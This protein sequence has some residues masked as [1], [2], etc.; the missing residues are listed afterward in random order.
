MKTKSLFI[1][2][3]TLVWFVTSCNST[4]SLRRQEFTTPVK[5]EEIVTGCYRQVGV[6]PAI[7]KTKTDT[8]H[9]AA[10]TITEAVPARKETVEEKIL[11]RDAYMSCSYNGD[12]VFCQQIPAAYRV[13]NIEIEYPAHVR[14]VQT[15]EVRKIITKPILV[16]QERPD[17]RQV[18]CP[19]DATPERIKKLQENLT[20]FRYNPGPTDGVLYKT[21]MKAIRDYEIKKGF[22]AEEQSGEDFIMQKTFTILSR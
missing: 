1:F 18:V 19:D 11:E 14:T 6:I 15:S 7:Y 4:V 21:T 17:I 16:E 13:L 5:P 8:M 22:K 9:E 20:K 10:S 3:L 2:I 12:I